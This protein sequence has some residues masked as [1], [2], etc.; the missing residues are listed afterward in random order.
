MAPTKTIDADTTPPIA[1][2]IKHLLTSITQLSLEL[3]NH[4]RIERNHW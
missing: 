2:V 4:L 3:R 1:R